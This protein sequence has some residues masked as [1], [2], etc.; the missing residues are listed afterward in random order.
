ME[1]VKIY[2]TN[3]DSLFKKF[4]PYVKAASTSRMGYRGNQ[5]VEYD[6]K[7]NPRRGPK[8]REIKIT[9]YNGRDG[10]NVDRFSS[11]YGSRPKTEMGTPAS[12]VYQEYAHINENMNKGFRLPDPNKVNFGI[13]TTEMKFISPDEYNNLTEVSNDERRREIMANYTNYEQPK[14]QPIYNGNQYSRPMPEIP[15]RPPV[16]PEH[17]HRPRPEHCGRPE[18][19]IPPTQEEAPWIPTVDD[20][21]KVHGYNKT[22]YEI[23][24]IVS[25]QISTCAKAI[26]MLDDPTRPVHV[27]DLMKLMEF[28]D[29]NALRV[30]LKDT[31]QNIL[32]DKRN[33]FTT[34][35]SYIDG[36]AELPGDKPDTTDPVVPTPENPDDNKD[37]GESS[38]EDSKSES[39][40]E[41][42]SE[43][44]N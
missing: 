8:G 25:R 42:V 5:D 22:N 20:I 43:E 41:T 1:D 29:N 21:V 4:F 19:V 40:D 14:I 37:A 16:E 31:F 15:P 27:N 38:A 2:K 44:T 6:E 12:V 30:L 32:I 23:L 18:P 11:E 39:V 36:T 7:G 10:S 28:L 26:T 3:D 13:E 17:C 33:L 35:N 9:P 34:T 24:D